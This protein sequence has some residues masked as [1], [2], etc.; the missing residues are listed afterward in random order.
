VVIPVRDERDGLKLV[1]EEIVESGF[2]LGKVIVVDGGSRDG[3]REVAKS[4]GV[5]VVSQRYPGGKAGGVRTGLE[6]ARTNHVVI[7][8]GD[9]T[10]PP[11][12]IWDLCRKLDEG[13]DMV[14]G[15]RR[16]QP[17]AMG[18]IFK[19]G[20]W[21]LTT[22]FNIVFGT[23][24]RDV[25]SG[26]YALRVE[27][28]REA[29][30]E[31]GGFSVESEIVAHIASTTGR[32]AEVDIVYRS[33]V[34]EKKLKPVHGIKILADMIRLSWSYNPVFTLF[35]VTSLIL[36]PG[37]ALDIYYL[38]NLVFSDVKYYMKG[39]LGAIMTIVGLQTLG[40]AILALYMKRMEFRLRRA[41]ER[42]LRNR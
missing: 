16:P 18:R 25:L 32:I 21:M 22:W 2:D 29:M 5:M 7:L 6:L 40:I 34:G 13:Y 17:G 1:L 3:T 15:V 33:R 11:A 30:W 39:L 37:V 28:L 31:A 20:N 23:K 14:I 36:I 42:V 26:M 41:I 12:H 19:V 24:L 8:D 27:A 35:T 10:Y 38:Y 9:H 4:Y